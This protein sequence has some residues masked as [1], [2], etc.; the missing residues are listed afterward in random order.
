MTS[1]YLIDSWELDNALTNLHAAT[2]TMKTITPPM[3]LHGDAMWIWEDVC[4]LIELLGKVK[5]FVP[6]EKIAAAR[7]MLES[8]D[9]RRAVLQ[10]A[11]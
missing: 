2:A 4:D 1:H 3:R 8:L 9:G 11:E 10:A 7:V 6:D 5:T